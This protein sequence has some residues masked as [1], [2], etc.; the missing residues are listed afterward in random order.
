MVDMEL[1]VVVMPVCDVARAK[2]F[3][4]FNYWPKTKEWNVSWEI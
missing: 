2:R 3:S 1:E 4:S